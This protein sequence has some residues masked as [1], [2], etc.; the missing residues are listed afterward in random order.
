MH[1][2]KRL[3]R[4]NKEL[5]YIDALIRGD[6][7]LVRNGYKI[8][9]ADKCLGI[10]TKVI[11]PRFKNI[12]GLRLH[13]RKKGNGWTS[14][15]KSKQLYEFLNKE[16][17]IPS[18]EKSKTVRIP[19]QVSHSK[20]I[21]I[22]IWHLKGWMDAEGSVQCKK[23]KTCVTPRISFSCKNK[24]VRDGL[25]NIFKQAG[26]KL[27][28]EL[29]VWIWKDKNGTF[30]FELAGPKAVGNYVKHVGFDHPDKKRKISLLLKNYKPS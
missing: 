5:S 9:L 11:N 1:K 2:I 28:T 27:K 6:G 19:F 3:K 25:A 16:L 22:K 4:Y 30:G 26:K 15:I 29:P 17:K 10:H 20:D 24:E 18:G 8:E 14:V 21:K 13:L 23:Y 7:S 12:F